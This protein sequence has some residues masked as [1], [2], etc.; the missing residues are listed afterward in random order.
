MCTCVKVIMI[1]MN[2]IISI[3][4]DYNRMMMMMSILVEGEVK[5]ESCMIN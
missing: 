1:V 4:I 5:N 3:N 2:E